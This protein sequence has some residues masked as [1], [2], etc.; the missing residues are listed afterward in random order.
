M[1]I[2]QNEITRTQTS[3]STNFGGKLRVSS[4]LSFFV[5]AS[6]GARYIFTDPPVYNYST[7]ITLEPCTLNAEFQHFISYW[8]LIKFPYFVD[9][10]E[11][12]DMGWK[13]G[14]LHR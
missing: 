13:R 12:G 4:P 14:W 2:L 10:T 1:K 3:F 5:I 7:I 11:R 6:T 9:T 8:D